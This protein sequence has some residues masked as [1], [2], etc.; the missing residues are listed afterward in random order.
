MP[1]LR[2]HALPTDVV[3]AYQAGAPDAYGN[4]PETR[5][6]DGPGFPCR[7]CLTDI[8]AGEAVLV[9]AHRPFD[10]QQPY[11]ETGPI[12]LHARPCERHPDSAETPALFLTRE[13]MIVRGYGADQRIV[14]GTGQVVPVNEIAATAATIL[15]RP[16]IAFVDLR[17]A[18]N[19][20]YQARVTRG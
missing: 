6:S 18:A 4:K 17:S 10:G 16:D 8:A 1:T 5:L 15:E 7:H 9:L 13:K 12:F 11:A 19:N 20:C 3:R 14:Y 2:F